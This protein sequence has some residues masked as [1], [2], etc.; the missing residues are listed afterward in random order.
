MRGKGKERK[1][2]WGKKMEKHRI[3]KIHV[4]LY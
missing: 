1:Q 3:E 2:G 4:P